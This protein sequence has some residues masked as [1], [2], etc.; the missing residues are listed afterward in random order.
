VLIDPNLY[1]TAGVF[2]RELPTRH[3]SSH[4]CTKVSVT[5]A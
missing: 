3:A 5:F 2:K 1:V 4:I